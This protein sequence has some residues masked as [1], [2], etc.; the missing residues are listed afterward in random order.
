MAETLRNSAAIPGFES[1]ASL[2]LANVTDARDSHGVRRVRMF[3]IDGPDAD[4][5]K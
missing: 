2:A 3:A 1:G 4:D 5:Q